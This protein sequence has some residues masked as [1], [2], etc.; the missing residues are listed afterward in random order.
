MIGALFT[1]ECC[2]KGRASYAA[3]AAASGYT[4]RQ[5]ST[6]M[7]RCATC[8]MLHNLQ[9][10]TSFMRLLCRYKVH[11]LLTWMSE[12]CSFA[13]CLLTTSKC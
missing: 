3:W 6:H 4:T 1:S 9:A 5:R 2:A 8:N 7:S 13:C 11:D 10:R 12:G